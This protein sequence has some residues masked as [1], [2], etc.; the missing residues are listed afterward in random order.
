MTHRG[1]PAF[2]QR[3]RGGRKSKQKKPNKTYGKKSRGAKFNKQPK[4]KDRYSPV[5]RGSGGGGGGGFQHQTDEPEDGSKA[6]GGPL[7]RFGEGIVVEWDSAA[8]NAVFGL[9]SDDTDNPN[10]APY[11]TFKSGVMETLKDAH[12]EAEQ[13]ARRARTKDG[14]NLYDCLDEFEKEEILSEDDKWYCPRCKEHCRAAKKFDLWLTPDVLI[15]H[16]KRFSSSGSRRDKIDVNVDF[17]IEGLD[18]SSRVLEKKDGKQEVYDLIAIDDHMGGLGG[19][20]YTG[21]AKNFQDN[22]WYKYDDT[23]VS[24]PIKNTKNMISGHAYLLFY[25]R[26]SDRPLGGPKLEEAY[27]KYAADNEPEVDDDAA[28]NSE[29]T[30]SR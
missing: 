8:W 29:G 10:R 24:G 28:Q 15:V 3:L 23:H 21:C 9:E 20:H 13:L 18:I 12:L 27:R 17:P 25:R 22:N 30:A 4:T 14:I 16:L 2:E 1:A 6:D 5:L 7:I 26:R 19:G 11:S